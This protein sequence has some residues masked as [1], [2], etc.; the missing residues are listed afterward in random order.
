MLKECRMDLISVIL[1][2][3][4]AANNSGSFEMSL[5]V[6]SRF[7]SNC[8]KCLSTSRISSSSLS[9]LVTAASLLSPVTVSGRVTANVRASGITTSNVNL[10]DKEKFGVKESRGHLDPELSRES[11]VG[12]RRK[13]G[14]PPNRVAWKQR[15]RARAPS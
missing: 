7:S 3:R 10:V 4:T 6:L 12:R 5:A 13:S 8:S 14:D 11:T 15:P 2:S 1:E 9:M